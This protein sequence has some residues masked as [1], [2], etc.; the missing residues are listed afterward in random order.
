M[1]NIKVGAFIASIS[2][3]MGAFGA[4]LL[5]DKLSEKSLALYET[6]VRY[7][8]Y[9]AFALIIVGILYQLNPN[10]QFKIATYF[11]LIGI[12]FFSGSLYIL[13]YKVN[14]NIEG[15]KWVGPITPLGGLCFII[16]WLMV[17]FSINLKKK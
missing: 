10:K 16:G 5:K 1:K 11:F 17:A 14:N 4:H 6:G 2:I 8:L 12:L 15:L 13:S 9:H 3:I 7:Q